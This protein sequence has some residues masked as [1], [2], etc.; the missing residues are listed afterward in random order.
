M[1][2]VEHVTVLV[3]AASGTCVHGVQMEAPAAENL[4]DVHVLQLFAS[5]DCEYCCA[6]HLS[7]VVMP[8]AA[9]NEP[10]PDQVRA[11]LDKALAPQVRFVEPRIDVSGIDG[12]EANVHEVQGNLPRAAYSRASGVDAQHGFFAAVPEA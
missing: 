4:P 12:F 10:D 9:W 2:A 3:G 7:H 8:A 6:G 5:V 11:H 1:L